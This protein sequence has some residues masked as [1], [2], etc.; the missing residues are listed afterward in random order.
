MPLRIEEQSG[1]TYFVASVA[2][3]KKIVRFCTSQ[4]QDI[5]FYV[6][7]QFVSAT[8]LCIWAADH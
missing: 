5:M 7:A 6:G 1:L 2:H 4:L 3:T 8:I